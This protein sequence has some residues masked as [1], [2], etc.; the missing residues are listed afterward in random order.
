[1]KL[2][3]DKRFYVYIC[4]DPTKPG[5]YKYGEYEFGYEPFYVGKGVENRICKSKYKYGSNP[6]K[7]NKIKKLKR[8]GF[9]PIALKYVEHLTEF[10]AFNLEIN[11][12]RTIGRRDK[13]EGPLTNLT[14]GGEGPSGYIFK[15]KDIEK[16]SG[17]NHHFYGKHHTKESREKISNALKGDKHYLYGRHL[18]EKT[19]RK[20]SVSG[21]IRYENNIHPRF[22]THHSKEAIEKIKE[23]KRNKNMG[24]QNPNARPVIVNHKYYDS[25]ADAIRDNNISWTIIN[26][27]IKKRVLGYKYVERVNNATMD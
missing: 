27:R 16:I 8:C 2:L 25:V 12:V 5:K 4:L 7:Y 18:P 23:S 11:M 10:E 3:E 15:Q 26:Y 9:V 13:K 19:K 6:F 22:G 17:K 20:M 1:M 21:K 24:G 14:Y